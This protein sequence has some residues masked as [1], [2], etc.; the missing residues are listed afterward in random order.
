M[1]AVDL[2]V[3]LLLSLGILAGA[4][5]GLPGP[6]LGLLGAATGLGVAV[7]AA[8]MLAETLLSIDQ[9]LRGLL[10]IGGL[11]FLILVG[12]A[13]GAAIRASIVSIVILDMVLTLVFWGGDPGF[14]ISG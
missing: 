6:V 5:A 11:G 13:T 14:R 12:E 1:N 8:S 3:L 9:P 2:L 10:V 7:V 4:R